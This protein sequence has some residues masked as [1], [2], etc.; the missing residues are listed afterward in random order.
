MGSTHELAPLL[1]RADANAAI[2]SG[3]VMRCLALVQAWVGRGG[4]VWFLSRCNN[5]TLRQRIQAAGAEFLSLAPDASAHLD[6]ESMLTLL[7]ELKAAYVILDGYD[8]DSDYQCA[9]R[10]SGCR[11]LVIDDT[12]RLAHYD[13][14]ILLNQN[15]GAA[16]L[17]YDCNPDT[18]I[19]LGPEYALLRREFIFWRSRL[20]TVPETARK[21]LVTLG[22]SDPDNV[23]LKVIQALRRLET[24]RLQIRVVAGPA[25][26]HID[27]LND[28]SA[29]FPGRLEFLTAVSDMA[30]LMAWADLAVTAAGSTCWELAC[31]GLPAVSLVIA[32][33]QRALAGELGAAGVVI[34]LGW[35]A[36]V[37]VERLANA[38]DGLLFSS[39]RRLRM[40]QR[41][42][43]LVDGK[44]VE[45]VVSV[46]LKRASMRAA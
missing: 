9:V 19:L 40:G 15:L 38:V 18:A 3:H 24:G 43:A 42:R 46:L 36:E 26:P 34:N 14:D 10:T 7:A 2:G 45:R 16:Q 6:R 8:F 4:P 44:G 37:S 11:L 28:A 1:V 5:P 33:N 13:A 22:G 35:H 25:N 29:A 32:A 41:G 21:I 30:P 20:H 17:K 31:L 23:T 39:F 27:E 12:V